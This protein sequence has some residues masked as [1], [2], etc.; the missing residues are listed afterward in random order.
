MEQQVQSQGTAMVTT[1]SAGIR[2]GV[3]SGLVGIVYFVL[4]T[5]LG[6]DLNEGV[7]SWL[8][9]LITIA[10]VVLAHKYY[11]DNT[12]GFMSYGEGVTISVWM[13]LISSVMGSI[14]FYIYVKFID[15]TFIQNMM[16]MQMAKMEEKGMSD[17]QIQTAMGFMSKMMNPEVMLLIGL[18]A[19][20]IMTLI[21][22]LIVSIFTQKKAPETAF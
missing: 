7:W 8:R 4:F 14:F 3:I 17:E 12:N 11:K 1:R 21:I 10:F 22:G 20:F 2:Y 16:D 9:Y 13:G 18:F 15:S 5:N 6:M 19:G